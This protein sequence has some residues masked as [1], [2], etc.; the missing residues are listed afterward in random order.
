MP[1]DKKE[2]KLRN[3]WERYAPIWLKVSWEMKW[4]LFLVIVIILF[5]I[6]LFINVV[7][8]LSHLIVKK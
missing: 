4:E 5:I 3:Y 8:T 2:M 7:Y 6:Y 1:T